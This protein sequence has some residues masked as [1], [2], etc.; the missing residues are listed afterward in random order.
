MINTKETLFYMPDKLQTFKRYIEKYECSYFISMGIRFAEMTNTLIFYH[1]DT[2]MPYLMVCVDED[3]AWPRIYMNCT[4]ENWYKRDD[5]FPL[6]KATEISNDM[7]AFIAAIHECK[8][9]SNGE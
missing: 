6:H 4:A 2:M 3:T 8:E 5:I 7:N 9:S 1:K